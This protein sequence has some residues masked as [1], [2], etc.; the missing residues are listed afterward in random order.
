M[1]KFNPNMLEDPLG[2]GLE[3]A[4]GFPQC[5][6]DLTKDLL[7]LLPGDILGG[8][9][10][11]VSEGK[12][13][14]QD[15]MAGIFE[16]IHDKLGILEYDSTTGKLSLLGNSSQAG[17]DK[18]A[19]SV[20]GKVGETLG[21]IAGAGMALYQAGQDV[22]DQIEAIENCLQEYKDFLDSEKDG[23]ESSSVTR[24]KGEF[25]V[26]KAQAAAA[27]AY[28]VKADR[29]LG[30]IATVLGERSENPDLIPIF[31]PV[32]TLPEEVSPIFRLTFGPP[33]AKQGQFLLSVDGLYYD[34]QTRTYADG[35]PVPTTEDLKFIPN[36][37]RWKLD[38]SPNLGGRGT[39]YSIKDLNKYVDTIFDLTKI[40][41]TNSLETFYEADHFLQVLEGQRNQVISNLGKN[42][43]ELQTT[44]YSPQTA[45][46]INYTEQIKSQN[47]AFNRKINK[48]K[49]QIEVAVKA[50]DLFGATTTFNI[51]EIPINDFSF[52]SSVN[53]DVE[54]EQQRGLIFDH[55]EISG[56]VL[57]IVPI[58]VHSEG[59]A[60]KVV[61]TPIEV[62]ETGVGSNIDGEGLTDSPMLSL[63]TNIETHGLQAI[64][65]FT[66]VNI[67]LPS[68]NKF[69]TLNCVALGTE[70]R[71]QTVSTNPSLL[72]QEGL[73]LPYL[74]GIPSL[75]KRNSNYEFLGETWD[76]YPFTIR[77]SGNY[78]KFPDTS[79]FQNL[80]YSKEGATIDVWTY[81]PGLFS[82]QIYAG[83][84]FSEHALSTSAFGYELSAAGGGWCDFHYYRVLLGCENTGGDNLNLDQSAV[85]IDR[86]ST[87][88]R[89][90]VM[91]F[92]RDP[93]MFY[94]GSAVLPASTDL[95]PRENFGGYVTSVSSVP[96]GWG[97]NGIEGN[98]I[99]SSLAGN[100]LPQAFW[101]ASGTFKTAKLLGEIGSIPFTVTDPGE[102][103]GSSSNETCCVLQVSG[104]KGGSIYV[105][106]VSSILSVAPYNND[107]NVGVTS[108]VFFIAPTQSYNTSSV[109]FVKDATCGTDSADILK[110]VVSTKSSVGGV[111]FEDITSKF[112]NLQIVFDPPNNLIKFYVN[113]VLFKEQPLSEV[114]GVPIGSAPQVPSF[115]VPKD[116]A[117]SS[118]YY[119]KNTVLQSSGAGFGQMGN[120]NPVTLFD[121]GPATYPNFTP[122]IM[123][124]GWTDG[125][126]VDLGTSSG[127]FL[128]TG[129]GIIS[130]YNGNVGNVKIYNRALNTTELS[131]NY[132]A[133]RDFFANV[134]L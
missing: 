85:I 41:N 127:G 20:L 52:L 26:L 130:C 30:D 97:V 5:L 23:Q 78:V 129:A 76:S 43:K 80:M 39:A 132:K 10:K 107:Y 15:A 1:T 123:G 87:N 75:F 55:G 106:G 122:W 65:N 17:V 124:G 25:F 46:H 50:P 118:F 83:D 6:V 120:P 14:A 57:P 63:T 112:V 117:T 13:A 109:G 47:A 113:G 92:S 131:K 3:L 108:S 48:R 49:K 70:N 93:R 60:N 84:N 64:Y 94:E 81:M 7:S 104:E 9:A 115:I 69:N 116:F 133:Q 56:I 105:S 31:A 11:G 74:N 45:L 42:I 96:I 134:D 12:D 61:L 95:N 68:S 8:I 100:S 121:N 99:I 36:Q 82:N 91:G 19:D 110:F 98:W 102:G 21:F 59:I 90:M 34:S 32:D 89:G 27:Q 88:V 71:A 4:F 2:T 29:V 40:D 58:Y 86:D 38:H 79:S 28:I 101:Q 67:Q 126:P 77:D 53:L 119:S 24:T 125:R 18:Q 35:S 62:S 33:K 66:D 54:L 114:F 16:D 22:M 44:G 111:D 128:D 37:D 103:Y 51:G 73:G 72:Y